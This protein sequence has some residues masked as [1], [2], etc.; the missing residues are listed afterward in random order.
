MFAPPD[1]VTNAVSTGI[2]LETSSG[3]RP[4]LVNADA[5]LASPPADFVIWDSALAAP[6]VPAV[7]VVPA[8]GAAFSSEVMPGTALATCEK[9]A[10]FKRDFA[11][12]NRAPAAPAACSGVDPISLDSA[13]TSS[14][15]AAAARAPTACGAPAFAA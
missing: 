6:D 12:P 13:P 1:F 14:G 4:S 9:S 2:A 10:G 5:A 3:L 8:A 7:P 11:T 15:L